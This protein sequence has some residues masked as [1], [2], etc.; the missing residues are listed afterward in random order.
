MVD[1][2]DEPSH[3]IRKT[4]LFPF[5]ISLIY[6]EHSGLHIMVTSRMEY[7]IQRFFEQTDHVALD[8]SAGLIKDDIAKHIIHTLDEDDDLK[9]WD[10]A[11][12]S[13]IEQSL[14]NRADNM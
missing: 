2:I 4:E 12:R 6:S 1:A 7:N 10:K 5:L 14:I 13:R 9:Q 8:I 11:T 3:D